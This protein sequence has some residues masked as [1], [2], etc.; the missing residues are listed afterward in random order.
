M[1]FGGTASMFGFIASVSC[2]LSIGNIGISIEFG[3][4]NNEITKLFKGF[5]KKHILAQNK[6]TEKAA[7][8]IDSFFMNGLGSI[9][10][11]IVGNIGI[12][13][14][15][16]S[17]VI[18]RTPVQGVPKEYTIIQLDDSSLRNFKNF[19]TLLQSTREL[20]KEFK[21]KI[22]SDLDKLF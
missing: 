22:V 12:S 2:S 13:K 4:N 5:L 10:L 3:I 11:K 17:L 21:E 19:E 15:Q 14:N 6:D 20:G 18:V 9:Q 8:T 16:L 7:G 1:K